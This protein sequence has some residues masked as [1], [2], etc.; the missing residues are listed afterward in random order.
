MD[1]RLVM[2]FDQLPSEL[3]RHQGRWVATLKFGLDTPVKTLIDTGTLDVEADAR[4]IE[5]IGDSL[6]PLRM[7]Q[8]TY[9]AASENEMRETMSRVLPELRDNFRKTSLHQIKRD[10]IGR[11]VDSLGVFGA[12]E[13]HGAQ[14]IVPEGNF[15][16]I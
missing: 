12:R 7:R 3:D 6:V 1:W 9:E 11:W 8:M 2:Q 16:E 5:L 4:L 15:E 13:A 10:L 14:K